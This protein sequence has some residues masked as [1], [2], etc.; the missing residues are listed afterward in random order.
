MDRRE[1]LIQDQI[2]E[3]KEEKDTI[4]AAATPPGRGAVSMV[5]ISGPSTFSVLEK[6]FKP[7]KKQTIKTHQAVYGK[8]R[9]QKGRNIDEV[10]LL[11]FKSPHSFSTEDTAEIYCHGNPLIINEIYRL[12]ESL[13]LRPA[14]NGEF[15]ERAFLGGR[16]DLTQAEAIDSLIRARSRKEYQIWLK[17]AG[18]Y[19]QN[20]V[21]DL[22][23]KLIDL[24]ADIEAEIDFVEE[25]EVFAQQSEKQKLAGSII[26]YVQ[27]IL[28]HGRLGEKIQEGFR[29]AIVGKPNVGKSSIMNLLLNQERSIVTDIPGTTRDIIQ[30]SLHIGGSVFNFIDT[31]GIRETTEQIEKIG[32]ERSHASME[33]AHLILFVIDAEQGFAK[34][35]EKIYKKIVQFPH[36]FL[37]NKVDRVNKE[38]IN[39]L[40]STLYGKEHILFSAKEG[41]GLKKL[42]E[43]LLH[44]ANWQDGELDDIVIIH[45]RVKN[46]LEKIE[47]QLQEFLNLSESEA[48]QE[49]QA[50]PL[51]EAIHSLGEITGQI[52]S[53]EI[54]SSIFR[55]FCIGK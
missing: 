16:I 17:Q 15:T 23:E 55:R 29:I 39:I 6:I 52:G 22:R 54:L 31:A 1:P 47:T 43:R 4:F 36:L 7:H 26:N 19:F 11:V 5:R 53:E 30:E 8:I 42:E 32:I 48:P 50:I 24:L 9:D 21:D 44:L 27:E 33:E 46:L 12:L 45:S 41:T 37:V 34:E 18:G 3:L 25:G 14:A 51:R 20:K 40:P 10:I 49:I 2:E 35:D 38:K 13:N 28:A